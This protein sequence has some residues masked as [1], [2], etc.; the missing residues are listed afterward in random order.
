MQNPSPPAPPAEARVLGPVAIK[1]LFI[2]GLLALVC[3]VLYLVLCLERYALLAGTGVL[4][5][6]FASVM[7]LTRDIDWYEPAGAPGGGR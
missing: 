1:L 5:A 4:F 3:G 2:A 6:A 7:Y